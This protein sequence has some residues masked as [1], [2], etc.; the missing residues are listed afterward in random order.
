VSIHILIVEDEAITSDSLRYSLSR[1]G[2]EVTI[3]ATGA[4]ALDRFREQAP[5]L[6]VLDVMLRGD[7]DG[8]DVLRTVRAHSATPVIML[9]ALGEEDNVVSGLQ[10]GADDYLVKPFGTRE[11]L[12]RIQALLRRRD[13]DRLDAPQ[14][15]TVGPVTL[16]AQRRE[17]TL[18]GQPLELTTREFDLLELLM[19]YAGN[20]VPRQKLL[21]EVWGEDWFGD[22]RTLDV[23]VHGLRRRVE[24]VP[25][26][27]RLI[28]TA[29]GVGYRFIG[30]D[31]WEA[32]S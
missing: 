14:E 12:A 27:P 10:L 19:R 32:D 5:D 8:W 20:V 26:Q 6:I 16:N 1:Q 11:L 13:L 7:L 3:A 28:L 2:Y 29:R 4:A 15:L 21:D 17:A 31:E 22:V 23:H 18:N 24:T 30:I 25:T 9:T